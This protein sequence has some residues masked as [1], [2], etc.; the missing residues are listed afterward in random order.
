M[1]VA[2]ESV[3]VQTVVRL[4]APVL[5]IYALYVIFHGHYSPGGGFQ[6]GVVLAASYILTGLAFGRDAVARHVGEHALA[7]LA[8]AG[9]FV[10]ALVGVFSFASGKVFLDYSALGFTSDDVATRRSF[11]ILFVELGVALT[12]GAVILLIYLR[13]ADREEA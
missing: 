10:Y 6:G 8:G 7:V 3:T 9:V 13:L 2:H 12:V 4:L 1:R 11:G 5:Q